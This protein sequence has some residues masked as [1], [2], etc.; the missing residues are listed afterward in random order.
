MANC[1]KYLVVMDPDAPHQTA[2]NRAV[3]LAGRSGA[4]VVAFA[5]CYLSEQDMLHFNSRH[6]AKHDARQRLEQWLYSQTGHLH[7]RVRITCESAWNG[8][9][10][11]AA[12]Y[13][14]QHHDACMMFLRHHDRQPLQHWL[15]H[16]PCPLYLTTDRDTLAGAH[17]VLATI[18]P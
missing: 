18:D 1:L 17:P 15:E 10:I 11:A 7:G 12:C 6:E 2:L 13:R 9:H 5:C 4:N 8:D 3:A 14:A 16:S